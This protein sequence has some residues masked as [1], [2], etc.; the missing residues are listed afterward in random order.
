MITCQ[1]RATFTPPLVAPITSTPIPSSALEPENITYPQTKRIRELL[2]DPYELE[3]ECE[4][5][6]N[7]LYEA[8]EKNFTKYI[9][10]QSNRN[11]TSFVQMVTKEIN[12]I[13]SML[14]IFFYFWSAVS[15]SKK[16]TITVRFFHWIF[17]LL[18][19]PSYFMTKWK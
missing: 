17:S 9:A 7:L 16:P 18:K 12:K 19:G 15:F 5:R 2:K 8:I 14:C 10:E 6:Q 3:V 1:N 11:I 4:K 13:L